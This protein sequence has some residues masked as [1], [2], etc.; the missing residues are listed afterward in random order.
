MRHATAVLAITAALVTATPA[1]A[2]EAQAPNQDVLRALVTTPSAAERDRAVV[3]RFLDRDQVKRAAQGAGIDLDRVKDGVATLGADQAGD[4][5]QRVR[6]FDQ[7]ALVGGDTFV[8]SST[9]VIIALL[10]IILVIV[11]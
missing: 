9:F 11:A 4:L 7:Q 8:I 5:A 1:Q 3:Q 10:V 6:D 2:Q